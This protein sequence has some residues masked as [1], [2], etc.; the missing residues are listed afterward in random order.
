ML[1]LAIRARAAAMMLARATDH[2]PA[3][4]ALR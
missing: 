4:A 2:P 1:L 3:D